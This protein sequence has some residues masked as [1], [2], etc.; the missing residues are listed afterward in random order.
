GL[1]KMVSIFPCF[2]KTLTRT[3]VERNLEIPN[4]TPFLPDGNGLMLV[5]DRFG[6]TYQFIASE[7]RGGRRSLTNDWHAFAVSKSLQV[8]DPLRICR[9]ENGNEYV[10]QVGIELFGPHLVWETL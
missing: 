2:K 10:V 9:L 8:G 7:R 4:R 5:R 1:E 3:D 6:V